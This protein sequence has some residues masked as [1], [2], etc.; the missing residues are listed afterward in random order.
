MGMYI[1]CCKENSSKGT[2]NYQLKKGNYWYFTFMLKNWLDYIYF[3]CFF[4]LLT[5]TVYLHCGRWRPI[6]CTTSG[7]SVTAIKDAIT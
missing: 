1:K 7:S 6:V 2:V 3:L 5:M 4:L